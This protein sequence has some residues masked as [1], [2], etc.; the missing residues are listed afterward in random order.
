MHV[1]VSKMSNTTGVS[2]HWKG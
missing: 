1:S 2:F